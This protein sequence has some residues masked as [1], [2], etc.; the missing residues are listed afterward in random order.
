MSDRTG[1]SVC[2]KAYAKINLYLHI[3]GQR[4][5]GYHELDSLFAFTDYGDEL[6]V[7]PADAFSL[8][9]QGAYGDLLSD[10]EENLVWKAAKILADR[11]GVPLNGAVVLDKVLPVAAGLGGGSAD[12]AAVLRGLQDLW[13]LTPDNIE[14]HDIAL[15]LGADVPACL[16]STGSQAGGIGDE[17]RPVVLP[18][19]G[20]LLVNPNIGLQTGEVFAAWHDANGA[21]RQ[22]NEQ[23]GDVSTFAALVSRLKMAS[24]DLAAPALKL[25]PEIGGVLAA[26]EAEPTCALARMSGSGATCFGLFSSLDEAAIAG[27][28]LASARPDW[29]VQAT[30]L[31][32]AA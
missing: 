2:H 23:L 9:V 6:T 31:R 18:A 12:A 26:L 8:T 24:N 30:T 32:G 21:Y 1:P 3:T 25:V 5:D 7:S 28:K 17:L 15:K 11:M 10:P 27:K 19:C 22:A 14:L 13:K 20:V 16:H 29:W 4:P